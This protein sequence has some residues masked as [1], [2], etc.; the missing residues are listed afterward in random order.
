MDCGDVNKI[1][2]TND[3]GGGGVTERLVE[4]EWR[5][6]LTNIISAS[7]GGRWAS[8]AASASDSSIM[9]SSTVGIIICLNFLAVSCRRRRASFLRKAGSCSFII[10][11][12]F[13]K[14]GFEM[15]RCLGSSQRRTITGIYVFA[16][17]VKGGLYSTAIY[18]QIST[19]PVCPSGNVTTQAK[20]GTHI[21]LQIKTIL[22]LA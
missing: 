18:R 17:Q 10:S 7:S 15:G 16:L 5:G 22:P 3:S 20:H 8:N 21:P 11:M 13:W 1:C 6:G 19:A 9:K 12:S 2:K 4:G 14:L